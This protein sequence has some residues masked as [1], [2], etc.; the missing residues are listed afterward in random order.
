MDVLETRLPQHLGLRR[1]GLRR[2]GATSI[3]IA[4]TGLLIRPL[5]ITIIIFHPRRGI[6]SNGGGS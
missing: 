3:A 1:S 6:T 5:I 4:T 2:T